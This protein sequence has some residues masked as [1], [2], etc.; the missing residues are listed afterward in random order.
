AA[1]CRSQ[2]VHR[3]SLEHWID[4]YLHGGFDALL[5]PERR[6]VPQALSAT[7]RKVPHHILLLLVGIKGI[8]EARAIARSLDA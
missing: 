1:V 2:N 8:A 7:R 3:H 5:A 4:L 6:A